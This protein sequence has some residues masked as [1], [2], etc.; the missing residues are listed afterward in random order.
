M[1][2]YQ[3]RIC[4]DEEYETLKEFE[5][6]TEKTANSFFDKAVKIAERIGYGTITMFHDNV[7]RIK[8]T[9]VR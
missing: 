3:V 1:K 6:E 2:K 9:K 7:W 4:F 8:T 5:F